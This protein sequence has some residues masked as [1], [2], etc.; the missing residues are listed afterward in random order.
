MSDSSN[1]TLRMTING[2]TGASLTY[3]QLDG[4]FL[5]LINVID[6]YNNHIL[7]SDQHDAENITYNNTASGLVANEVQSALDEIDQNLETHLISSTAHEAINLEYN[8]SISGLVASSIQDAID[9]VEDR[10]TT[11]EN[12]LTNHIDDT[13]AHESSSITYNNASSG[14]SSNNVKGALDEIDEN[15]ETHLISSTAHEAI[16]LTYSN[17]TSGLTATK[18]QD[19]IDEVDSNQNST[20][21]QL[22]D[23]KSSST[24]HESSSITY[25][26]TISGLASTEVK[27]A[28][29]EL[30]NLFL[31]QVNTHYG[32]LDI[33]NNTTPISV[34]A[35]TDTT[36]QDSVDYTQ[37]TGI[38]DSIPHGDLN[39]ITQQTN[40]FTIGRDGVYKIQLW[41]VVESDSNNTIF[42][43]KFAVNGVINLQRTPKSRIAAGGEST[44]ISAHGIIQLTAGDVIT[45]WQAS[46]TTANL[47]WIDAVFSVNEL[48]TT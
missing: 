31:S 37:I 18:V 44:N 8:N 48:R 27:S 4:N 45:L 24:A 25:D 2:G 5:E 30:R 35:A 34:T 3:E 43:T 33:T 19:A 10:L 28:L 14:L 1:I 38:W 12:S 7:G 26:N 11:N 15:L 42:G 40:S 21:D 47:T 9:E 32:E 16:N 6:D 22:D 41:G 17:T 29:D 36:L 46:D 20:Q 39:G 23:H 13:S